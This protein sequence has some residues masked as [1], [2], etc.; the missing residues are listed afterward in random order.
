[1]TYFLDSEVLGL[2]YAG[3]KNRIIF[4]TGW[5]AEPGLNALDFKGVEALHSQ[6]GV[7]VLSHKNRKCD[8]ESV[9]TGNG[10]DR[11]V[12]TI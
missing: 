6:V 12:E 5:K 10:F 9:L 3:G 1:M 8:F 4:A 7:E 2:I 11:P